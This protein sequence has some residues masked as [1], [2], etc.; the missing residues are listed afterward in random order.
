[1]YIHFHKKGGGYLL[2]NWLV[3]GGCWCCAWCHLRVVRLDTF[4]ENIL[5]VIVNT[6]FYMPHYIFLIKIVGTSQKLFSTLSDK[7]FCEK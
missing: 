7:Q 6:I 3:G 2:K 1:M 5:T 4:V